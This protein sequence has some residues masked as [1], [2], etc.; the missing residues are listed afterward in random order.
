V[1][2]F[3]DGQCAFP[4]L[5]SALLRMTC[6]KIMKNVHKDLAIRMFIPILFRILKM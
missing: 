5:P 1:P 3:W 2:A 6:V 4:C